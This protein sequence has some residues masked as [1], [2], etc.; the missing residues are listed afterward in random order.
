MS[1]PQFTRV[2]IGSFIAPAARREIS[3]ERSIRPRS[4]ASSYLPALSIRGR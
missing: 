1:K 3:M 4:D 2:R